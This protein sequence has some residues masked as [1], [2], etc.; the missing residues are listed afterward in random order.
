MTSEKTIAKSVAAAILGSAAAL[1][2][3]APAL[4]TS[5]Y[6]CNYPYVCVYGGNGDWVSSNIV[7]RFRDIT[8]GFQY[9]S[10]NRSPFSVVS[11][12][13]DDTVYV[14]YR[15]GGENF[16]RVD[17]LLPNEGA[18]YNSTF[19]GIRIDDRPGCSGLGTP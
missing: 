5:Q 6:G 10:T 15:N 19:R 7:G 17:C 2:S 3:P 1:V 12:R 18:F 11:T 8:S 9:A 14:L 13:N 4:A 16:D